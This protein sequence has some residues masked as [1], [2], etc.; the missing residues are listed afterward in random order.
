MCNKMFSQNKTKTNKKR[1]TQYAVL[2]PHKCKT[3]TTQ[4][5][6]EGQACFSDNECATSLKT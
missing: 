1:F 3:H 6:V 5:N 2:P 4:N